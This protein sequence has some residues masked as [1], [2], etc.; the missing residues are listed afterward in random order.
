MRLAHRTG[1]D[2]LFVY[3][4]ELRGHHA[5]ALVQ[6]HEAVSQLQSAAADANKWTAVR[7]HRKM[8]E[9]FNRLAKGAEIE[10]FN[11]VVLSGFESA[12]KLIEGEPPHPESA[13]LLTTLASYGYW[14][15][16][17]QYVQTD[18]SSD[19]GERYARAAVAMAEQLDAPVELA[20]A[21]EAVGDVYSVRG[22][23]RERLQIAFRRLSLSRDPRFTDRRQQVD[24]L[25]QLGLALCSVGEY[26]QALPY[27]VEAEHLADEI[28]DLDEVIHA[29][30]IQAQCLFGLD[31]WDEIAEVEDKVPVLEAR[32]GSERVGRICRQC[33]V[34][35][36]IH[37]LR[38]EMELSRSHRQAAYN[39]MAQAWGPVEN[40]PAIGHY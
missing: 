27:L 13:R 28:R 5:E 2:D 31:R 12:L 1:G 25:C 6:Y 29:L 9:I 3:A 11:A 38:G 14:S 32:Y 18:A 17:Q 37:G 23:L 39:I 8:G 33:G 35:A 20:A 24:I 26:A 4:H 34:S 40:W 15:P 7:L 30:E 16:I 22:M 19:R 36:Y 21:L 10:Q